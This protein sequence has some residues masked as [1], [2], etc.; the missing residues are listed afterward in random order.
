MINKEEVYD[1]YTK[2]LLKIEDIAK[3]YHIRTT[4]ISKILKEYGINPVANKGRI[5]REINQ[6]YFSVIDTEA[7]AYFLGFITADGSIVKR[8][9][10]NNKYT[11]RISIKKEDAYLLEQFKKELC[12]Y[13]VT[14][15][16]NRIH[17]SVSIS[18]SN[19]EIIS[20]LIKY[21]V[22]PNKTYL[23]TKFYKEFSDINLLRHYLRGVFDGD[24]CI[25]KSKIYML[26]ITEY[27][28]ELVDDYASIINN[29]LGFERHKTVYTGSAYRYC[30]NGKFAK[31]VHNFLYTDANFFLER[32]KNAII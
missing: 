6:N 11:L 15:S 27:K 10:R 28:K 13:G 2:N 14:T 4:E 30:W 18:I 8:K 26:H 24:G 25:T 21:G 16:D 32:K 29:L 5:Y 22:V 31:A 17:P 12:Y 3:R 23:L 7:K 19:Q 1:L 9:D 20:D